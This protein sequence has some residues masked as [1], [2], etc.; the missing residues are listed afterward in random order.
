MKTLYLHRLFKHSKWAGVVLVIYLLTTL[1]LCNKKIDWV[2]IPRNDMFSGQ[3][4]VHVERIPRM[5]VNN[6][7]LRTSEMLYWKRE[8]L[9]QS[10]Q[11]YMN[12]TE[13]KQTYQLDWLK[14]KSKAYAWLNLFEKRITPNSPKIEWYAD[15][16]GVSIEN[17][18]IVEIRFERLD[19]ILY[20]QKFEFKP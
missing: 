14:R 17:N 10:M 18:D 6:E 20:H 4:I 15:M 8:F 9:E 16:A 12:A 3:P 7:P 13:H 5:Y 19:S 1:W 11:L 2:L